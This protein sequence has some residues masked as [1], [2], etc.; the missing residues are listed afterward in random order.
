MR[1]RLLLNDIVLKGRETRTRGWAVF[2]HW[3]LAERESVDIRETTLESIVWLAGVPGKRC[4]VGRNDNNLYADF[5]DE[6][7]IEERTFGVTVQKLPL[8]GAL[9]GYPSKSCLKKEA[10]YCSGWP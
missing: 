7:N 4:I 10:E 8:Q 3:R 2:Q 6:G 9:K 5:N 1:F